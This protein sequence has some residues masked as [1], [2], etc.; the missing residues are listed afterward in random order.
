M[1]KL[2]LDSLEIKNFRAFK[3]LRIEKL[4]RVNLIVGKNNI[5]K[6]SLLEALQLYAAGV[7]PT[8]IWNILSSRD[9]NGT[10]LS[11]IPSTE[12]ERINAVRTLFHGRKDLEENR[13][14]AEVGSCQ[15]GSLSRTFSMYVSELV[16]TDEG[17]RQV[18]PRADMNTLGGTLVADLAMIVEF[19][20]QT[21]YAYPL[22]PDDPRVIRFK[23][24][25][26]SQ[27]Y[28]YIPAS[29]LSA[30][31]VSSLWD[32]ISLT[33]LED[34]VLFAISLLEVDIERVGMVGSNDSFTRRYAIVKTRQSLNPFPLRSMGEGM[35]RMFGIALALVNA[36]DGMLLID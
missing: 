7:D 26:K 21:I 33:S 27:H 36:K 25:Y 28:A 16:S 23:T 9:E 30:V 2:V 19:G 5:G 1:S 13:E 14:I 34:D 35:S 8:I 22:S 3:H 12:K 10:T 15:P 31:Q 29:G 11:P 24:D 6:T 17:G 32:A 20:A 4:G 18:G